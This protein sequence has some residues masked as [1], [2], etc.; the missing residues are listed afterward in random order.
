LTKEQRL[1]EKAREVL[2]ACGLNE[3]VTMSFMGHK[4][5]DKINVPLD[6][7][8]RK[9]VKI[10]NPLGEDQSLMRTTLLPFI[11]NV[12]YTNYSRKVQDFKV[13]EISKIFM[14]KELP[15][16]ELPQEI[17]TIA[18]GMYG[19]DV[20][21]Y[22]LKGVIEALF[23]VMGIKG[24]EYVRAEDPSY[25]PGRSAKILLGDETL[26]IFGEIHPDVLENY[27]IPVRVYGG[28]IN[29]DKVI[30]YA[31]VEKKYMPLPKYPA[32]ERDIAVLVDRDIFVKDVE[33]VILETGG[34][35]IDKVELFDVYKG[36]NI[37][38][39]K[40]SVA[41]SIWYRSYERTLTDEEVNV[42]HNNIVEALD[43]KLGAKLR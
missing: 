29:L 6:S 34:K 8:F 37:P 11:L 35:L 19:K 24:V 2:L 32:V 20:D 22:S 38:E 13:F 10:I 28:E 30:Q 36:P 25:H 9:A 31:N 1:E 27:D 39:G 43:K 21:F 42:I 17:K 40:K 18:I 4:D 16:K 12:T 15:L 33:K 26:G 41:F 3:I 14:P 5:L 7:P 23:E